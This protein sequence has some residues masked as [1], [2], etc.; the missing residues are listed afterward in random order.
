MKVLL[1]NPRKTFQAGNIWKSVMGFI[2]PMGL[3][4]LAA[5][6]R[7]KKAEVSIIDAN[8]ELL[9][10][11]GL[12]NRIIETIKKSGIPQFTGVT[13]ST[14][15]FFPAI[16]AAKI[17]KELM[18]GT[19]LIAGGIH[20]TILPDDF[21]KYD[22]IDNCIRG[23]GEIPF[24]E[25]ISGKNKNS[26]LSLSYKE[27]GNIIHNSLGPVLDNLD[28]LPLPAYDLLPMSR[29][30]PSLGS[31]KKLP[32]VGMVTSRGCPGKCTFCYGQYFGK[33]IRYH[34]AERILA[35]ILHLKEFY[36]IREISFYDDTFTAVRPNLVKFC[37]LLINR[38]IDLSWSCFSRTDLINRDLLKLMKTA[39]CHQI[40]YGIES[41][42]EEILRNIQKNV[43]L[44]TAKEAITLT[45]TA[46]IE[47]RATFMIGNPGET[48]KTLK[49]TFWFAAD[50]DPDIALFN[51]TTPFPGTA[52]FEWASS[53]GYINTYNWADYDLSKPVMNIPGMTAD[54]ISRYYKL[55]NKRFYL[56][57]WYLMRRALKMTNPDMI[58]AGFS[59]FLTIL[60]K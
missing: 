58:K 48:V 39:G 9:D 43:S 12:K 40:C 10:E 6:L 50:I 1:I 41:G 37:N 22:F 38:R 56:R 54:E 27:N 34:S 5:Y 33:K 49:K 32:A 8:A 55:F 17:A 29:Y 52:M 42:D 30:K 7:E 35:E 59:A 46:G 53:N 23:E 25:L 4:Q 3:A 21:L 57:P 18:P 26:I 19:S 14:N 2:P 24:F 28:S 11:D 60:K 45:K 16:N 44:E 47:A 20:A 51:I 15:T 31:Y 13:A 36:G